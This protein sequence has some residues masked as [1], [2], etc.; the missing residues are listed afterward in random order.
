MRFSQKIF[1]RCSIKSTGNRNS[2]DSAMTIPSQRQDFFGR[3]SFLSLTWIFGVRHK[4][5]S[6]NPM[7][8]HLIYIYI[9]CI[10]IYNVYI[11]ILYIYFLRIFYLYPIIPYDLQ[12]ETLPQAENSW[13]VQLQGDDSPDPNHHSSDGKQWGSFHSPRYYPSL[14][15]KHVLL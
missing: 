15:N 13:N 12:S 3:R 2:H 14:H 1:M 5:S 4:H 10:Y 9:T 7:T 6:W 11:Y 8:F